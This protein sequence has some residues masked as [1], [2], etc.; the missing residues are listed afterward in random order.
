MEAE[1]AAAENGGA[2]KE[3]GSRFRRV[4]VFCGSSSGKR[5]SYRDAAVELGKE[6]VARKVDLVY[7]GPCHWRHTHHSH[8]QAGEMKTETH[9]RARQQR[10]TQQVISH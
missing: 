3:S 1:G 6:R 10:Q 4:C 7:G 9:E 5:S 8:G 2:G